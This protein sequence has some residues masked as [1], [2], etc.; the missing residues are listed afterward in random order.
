M[1]TDLFTIHLLDGW[2]ESKL[3][4][5]TGTIMRMLEA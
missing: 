3:C 1:Y 5:P 2:S 4:T